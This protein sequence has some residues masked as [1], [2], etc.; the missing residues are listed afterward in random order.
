MGEELVRGVGE[1]PRCGVFYMYQTNK[2][3]IYLKQK[4]SLKKGGVT[5][6][7]PSSIYF[8]VLPL[9]YADNATMEATVLCLVN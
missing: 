8:T 9:S 2:V 4:M 5:L 6:I 7:C 3:K 1:A